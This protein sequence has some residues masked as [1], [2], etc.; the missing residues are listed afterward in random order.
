MLWWEETYFFLVPFLHLEN[1]SR[2]WD[3]DGERAWGEER[4]IFL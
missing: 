1:W 4:H 2:A 3:E